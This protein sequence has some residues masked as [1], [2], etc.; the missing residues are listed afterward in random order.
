MCGA[1]TLCSEQG[2]ADLYHFSGPADSDYFLKMSPIG[3][4]DPDLYC[5]PYPGIF[6]DFDPPSPVSSAWSSGE[7]PLS[8]YKA[9]SNQLLSVRCL[10]NLT[11]GGTVQLHQSGQT[12]YSSARMT[13][14]LRAPSIAAG[15]QNLSVRC[16]PRKPLAPRFCMCSLTSWWPF[17][18][19]IPCPGVS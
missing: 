6:L 4:G 10:M 13:Q 12:M 7:A 3:S 15:L 18:V 2:S 14:P 9:R 16:A 19:H 11:L 17:A 8:G 5:S 1:K